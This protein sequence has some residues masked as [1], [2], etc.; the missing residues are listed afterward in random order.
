M[1]NTIILITHPDTN[2]P[3][4]KTK[5][6]TSHFHNIRFHNKNFLNLL[7]ARLHTKAE[8]I[9]IKLT[10]S[11][12]VHISSLSFFNVSGRSSSK[13]GSSSSSSTTLLLPNMPDFPTS[14]DFNCPDLPT[15]PEIS[16]RCCCGGGSINLDLFL[17]FGKLDFLLKAGLF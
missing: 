13:K 6:S 16:G 3:Q 2:L 9:T 11:S 14:P 4:I 8:I 1:K 17:S 5:T 12:K 7:I 15:L 10:H